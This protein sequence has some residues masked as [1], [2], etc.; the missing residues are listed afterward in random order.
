ML[1]QKPEVR[2]SQGNVLLLATF[3]LQFNMI[4]VTGRLYYTT[5]IIPLQLQ[6]NNKLNK[7]PQFNTFVDT[8][9]R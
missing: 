4:T 3:F 7:K 2:L 5:T 6:H 8:Q 1:P 9:H